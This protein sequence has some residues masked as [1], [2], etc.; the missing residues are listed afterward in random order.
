MWWILLGF[1]SAIPLETTFQGRLV[2]SAGA[3][4]DG[5]HTLLVRLYPAAT[6]GSD[7]WSQ[8]FTNVPVQD[9]FVSVRLTGLDSNDFDGSNLWVG[10]SLDGG[11]ELVPRQPLTPVPFALT[12]GSVRGG[13]VDASE[14]RVNGILIVDSNGRIP[15]S[16]LGLPDGSTQ[17]D[18]AA[19]CADV[20]T[21]APGATSGVRWLKW[22]GLSDPIQVWCDLSTEG[23]A[24]IDVPL[25]FHAPGADNARLTA[26][27]FS[28]QGTITVQA[29]ANSAN[30]KG[31][32]LLSTQ[33]GVHEVSYWLRPTSNLTFS[34]VRSSWRL[35]GSDDGNRC[36]TVNWIP[37]NGP[38]YNGGL[39][40]YLAAC[41]SGFTCIQGTPTEG[42]DAPIN[43][44]YNA[45]GLSATQILTWSG[46]NTGPTAGN[47]ARDSL[48]PVASPALY[49]ERLLIR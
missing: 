1:A 3:V 29:T 21:W 34:S 26:L 45:E 42:R 23:S 30:T 2:D 40:S 16:V 22:T 15:R 5:P 9:G 7:T 37:L 11:A 39:N 48:I 33:A 28:G 49:V 24:W 13:V 43:A 32:V 27:W 10:V 38:G 8:T 31:I 46:S 44:T 25:S 14:I 17:Q 19:S 35:Q 4:V 18:P 41:P 12:A 36:S 6:G 47:C 20:K